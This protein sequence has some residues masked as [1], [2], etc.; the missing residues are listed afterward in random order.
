MRMVFGTTRCV[1]MRRKALCHALTSTFQALP[2]AGAEEKYDGEAKAS[3]CFDGNIMVSYDTPSMALEKTNYI[4]D[5]GLGGAMWWES[6]ADKAN[7]QSLVRTVS[8]VNL[9]LHETELSFDVGHQSLSWFCWT[10]YG[11]PI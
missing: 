7:S 8:P 11:Q 2:L 10:R 4:R 5:R 1:Q 6:S 3:Y 9:M